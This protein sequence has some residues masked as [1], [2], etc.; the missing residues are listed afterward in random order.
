MCT[1]MCCLS[2]R[3]FEA[4]VVKYNGKKRRH[5]V[6]YGDGDREWL[7]FHH[8]DQDRIQLWTGAVWCQM[9]HIK[10]DW[11][12]TLAEQSQKHTKAITEAKQRWQQYEDQPDNYYDV[13]TAGESDITATIESTSQATADYFAQQEHNVTFVETETWADPNADDNQS[14]YDLNFDHSGYISNADT[15]AGDEGTVADYSGYANSSAYDE[16]QPAKRPLVPHLDLGSTRETTNEVGTAYES[17]GFNQNQ[18]Q[19]WEDTGF[20]VDESTYYGY[21]ADVDETTTTQSA[22]TE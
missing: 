12:L 5:K 19:S 9:R 21:S 4:K 8:D 3:W 15:T 10:P 16:V 13:T 18:G 6:E 20:D 22:A 17:N 7:S 1:L 14:N 2:I 11:R